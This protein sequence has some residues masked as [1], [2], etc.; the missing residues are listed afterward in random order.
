MSR[1]RGSNLAVVGEQKQFGEPFSHN[2][3]GFAE[4]GDG[5][6]QNGP[7]KRN[8]QAVNFKPSALSTAV[9]LQSLLLSQSHYYYV[10][11][12]W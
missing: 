7:S 5:F 11:K 8:E 3:K 4:A 2:D 12:I 10:Q 9:F 1:S 6:N